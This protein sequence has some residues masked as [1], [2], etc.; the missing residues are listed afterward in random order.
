[1]MR[2]TEANMG[3]RKGSANPNN[4]GHAMGSDRSTMTTVKKV[5]AAGGTKNPLAKAVTSL[6]KQHGC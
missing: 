5:A 4:S 3:M 2:P 1:M 6:R